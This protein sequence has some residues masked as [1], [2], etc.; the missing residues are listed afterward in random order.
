MGFLSVIVT[1]T[2][3]KY[4]NQVLLPGIPGVSGFRLQGLKLWG[5]GFEA[6]GFQGCW[7]FWVSGLSYSLA[8]RLPLAVA[9][10]GW[11][12]LSPKP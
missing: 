7:V 4:L 1:Q 5:L 8:L 6:L 10:G 9:V 12:F 11:F 2:P 3:L